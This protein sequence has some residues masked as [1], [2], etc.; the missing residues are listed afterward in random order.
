[1]VYR[2]RILGLTAISLAAAGVIAFP[3][4]AV[5]QDNGPSSADASVSEQLN[6][7]INLDV[8]SGNLYYAL[9]LMFDQLKVGNYTLP[10]A[11]KQ[12]EVSAHFTNL[13]IRTA[14]ET[15][16]KNSGYTYKV[17]GGVYSV[18]PKKIDTSD[19]LPADI[20]PTD[21]PLK[22]KKIYRLSS[23]Q[24]VYNAV[25]LVTRLGGRILPGTVG[26]PK[27]AGG[28]GTGGG[29]LGNF[30]GGGV[31]AGLSGGLGGF[32]GGLGGFGGGIGGV[33]GG[34]GGGGGYYGGGNNFGNSGGGRR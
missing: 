12:I 32:S 4:A 23:N 18:V 14:M 7:P 15:L 28:T 19:P 2:N 1:M 20:T 29:G 30:G 33:G 17:D 6:K 3:C 27:G 5:A 26:A 34:S 25:D 8:K 11:L 13:P 10:E 24:I 21:Q 22:G 31:G 16:L 9:T